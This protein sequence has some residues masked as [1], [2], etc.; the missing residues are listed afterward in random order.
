MQ[1]CLLE[2][3]FLSFKFEP[4]W[5]PGAL[6]NPQGSQYPFPSIETKTSYTRETLPTPTPHPC[7]LC[8]KR[9]DNLSDLYILEKVLWAGETLD[10]CCRFIPAMPR[11]TRTPYAFFMYCYS[12]W[13]AFSV[14]PK[15]K[16]LIISCL[17]PHSSFKLSHYG[18]CHL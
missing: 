18:P 16:I 17:L 7:P 4:S 15:Q 3:A 5:P 10:C 12:C 1:K 13:A 8:S 2:S 6:L 9:R 14:Q 11:D